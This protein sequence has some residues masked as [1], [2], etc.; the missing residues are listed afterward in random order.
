MDFLFTLAA[1]LVAITLLVFIHEYGHF[2]VARLCGIKVKRFSIGFG[3][4]FY[5]RMDKHGTQWAIA[6]FPLGGYISMVDTRVEAPAPGEETM[7]FDKKPLA[8]RA[9]VVLAGPLANLLFAWIVWSVLLS[10]TSEDLAPYLGSVVAS[11]PA[12]KAGFES[13]DKIIAVDGVPTRSL[14]EVHQAIA[15]GAMDR[16]DALVTV[17]RGG[18]LVALTLPST[19]VDPAEM[20]TGHGLQLL[21]FANPAGARVP[22]T[23]RSAIPGEPAQQ[24]GMKGGD[25]VV[26]IDGLDIPTW[27]AMGAVVNASA[28]KKLDFLVKGSDGLERHLAIT[29]RAPAS[30]KDGLGKVGATLDASALSPE[31]RKRAYVTLQRGVLDAMAESAARCAKFTKMTFDALASMATGRSGSENL[32]GPVGIAKQAGEAAESG[33]GGYGNFLAFLSLSLFFMNLLPLPGLD[34]GH[35]TMFLIEGVSRRPPSERFQ[36]TAAKIGFSL[37]AALM[38]FA[39]FNDISHLFK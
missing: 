20:T 32:S 28:G 33:V 5:T 12:D 10:G 11:S 8:A 24:G 9:A 1:F 4:P 3:T 18:K 35:L 19:A 23:I 25:T 27:S 14:G 26:S 39:L 30:A 16:K 13:T 7:A 29:P 31:Q 21:G 36:A 37:L 6:P 15:K 38:V 17:E 22:A 2:K 34:G